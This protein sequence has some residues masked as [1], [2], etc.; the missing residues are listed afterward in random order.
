LCAI[1]P[2]ATMAVYCAGKLARDMFHAMLAKEMAGKDHQRASSTTEDVVN[3]QK[4]SNV[5]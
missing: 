3:E 2:F 1:E 5:M 4:S